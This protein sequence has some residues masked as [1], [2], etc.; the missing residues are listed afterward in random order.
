MFC[1]HCIASIPAPSL[2]F[3]CQFTSSKLYPVVLGVTTKIFYLLFR[4]AALCPA[5]AEKCPAVNIT[6]APL[7]LVSFARLIIFNVGLQ[8]LDGS[9]ILEDWVVHGVHLHNVLSYINGCRLFL[10]VT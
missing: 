5:T 6:N 2:Y 7:F 4:A 10:V 3:F 8:S 1:C 9:S